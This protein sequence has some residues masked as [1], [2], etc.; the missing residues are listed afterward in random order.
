M[1]P[2]VKGFYSDARPRRTASA[3]RTSRTSTR[4]AASGWSGSVRPC[5]CRHRRRCSRWSSLGGCSSLAGHAASPRTGSILA[6]PRP[7]R[8]AG[9]VPASRRARGRRGPARRRCCSSSCGS[10]SPRRWRRP[11]RAVGVLAWRFVPHRVLRRVR[12]MV[13][14]DGPARLRDDAAHV[15][16][17]GQPVRRGE[18]GVA[19]R[20]SRPS[21]RPGA[22]PENPTEF[23]LIYMGGVVEDFDFGPSLKV[24]GRIGPG[25][26]RARPSPSACRSGCSRWSSPWRIGLAPGD[27][28]RPAAQLARGLLQHGAGGDRDLAAR[29]S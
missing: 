23:F 18:A 27:P 29:T 10:G 16:R 28:R 15:Q 2:H 22:C 17:A 13:P 26:A 9:L 4:C 24:Q 5:S 1:K 20:S 12:V 7:D 11:R 6:G 14:V 21:A 3:G 25:A 8:P 19:T